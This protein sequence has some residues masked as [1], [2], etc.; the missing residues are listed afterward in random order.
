MLRVG[1]C[2]HSYGIRG[3]RARVAFFGLCPKDPRLLLALPWMEAG[4]TGST[5]VTHH[6]P[7]SFPRLLQI[8]P[9]SAVYTA[10]CINV[11][12]LALYC[13]ISNCCPQYQVQPP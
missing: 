11:H 2:C 3:A 8:A 12:Y 4:Q 6:R 13:C 9:R 1:L 5:I 10:F 7:S